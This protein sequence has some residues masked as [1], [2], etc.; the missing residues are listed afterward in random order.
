MAYTRTHAGCFLSLSGVWCPCAMDVSQ[1][2]LFDSSQSGRTVSC[3][4][5]KQEQN[6]KSVACRGFIATPAYF[7]WFW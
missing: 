4:Q 6:R 3:G 1:P 5:R 2:W 7:C